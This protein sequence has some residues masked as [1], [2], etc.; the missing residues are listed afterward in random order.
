[1]GKRKTVK[2]KTEVSATF[3]VG[4]V[5]VH[6]SAFIVPFSVFAS[7]YMYN[8]LRLKGGGMLAWCQKIDC[9]NSAVQ[10]LKM[11]LTSA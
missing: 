10:K 8:H 7:I 11:N 6:R 9:V 2:R 3:K 4:P 5:H 1:M